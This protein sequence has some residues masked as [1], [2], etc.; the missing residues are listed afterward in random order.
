LDLAFFCE[1]EDKNLKMAKDWLEANEEDSCVLV[2]QHDQ[3]VHVGDNV[4]LHVQPRSN[5]PNSKDCQF[6]IYY[7]Q[8]S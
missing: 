2:Q 4:P 8:P 6:V 3:S 5:V 7:P 1:K